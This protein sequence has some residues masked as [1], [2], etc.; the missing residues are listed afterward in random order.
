[1]KVAFREKPQNPQN[2]TGAVAKGVAAGA[3]VSIFLLICICIN[4]KN[5]TKGRGPEKLSE[6]CISWKRAKITWKKTQK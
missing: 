3:V 1:M 4:K 2:F 6:Y 5:G